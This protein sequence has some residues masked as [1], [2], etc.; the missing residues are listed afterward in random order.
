MNLTPPIPVLALLPEI[1]TLVGGCVV[2]LLGQASAAARRALPWAVLVTLAVAL[3]ASLLAARQ[4]DGPLAHDGAAGS[5]LWISSL[6]PFVRIAALELGILLILANW[7]AGRT[8]DRGEFLAMMLFSISGLLLTSA[9]DNWLLL[10]LAVELVSIPTYVM[11]ILSRNNPRAL[12]A[13]AKYFY[14]GAMSAALLAYGLSFLYGVGGTASIR[15]GAGA[16][17]A[18]LA[19]PATLAGGLAVV[20]VVLSLAGVLFKLA[21]FPMHFYIADVYQGAASPVAGLLGF[22][23]KLAGVVALFKLV[24]VTG[25]WASGDG[26]MLWMLWLVAVLSMTVGNLLALRQNNIKRML[27]YSGVAHA[28]YMIVGV[29]A[30]PE[31]GK[32]LDVHGVAVLGDGAASVLYYTMIYGI[33]NLAAFAV[34]GLL[35]VRGLPCETMRDVTG[36]V[37]RE[38]LLAALLAVAMLTLMGLPPTPGFWGKLGLF[39]SALTASTIAAPG[40]GAW[41]IALVVIAVLNSALAAAYYLRV[42][43][44]MLFHDEE[45]PVASAPREA[46]STGVMLCA[47]LLLIFAVLPGVLY[48]PSQS[49]TSDIR[50]RAD[51]PLVNLAQQPGA[52]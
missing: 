44:A 48:T 43:A 34:L 13:G 14:L 30:G 11:V 33:A 8:E 50:A 28:G 22:V 49:A 31:A 16:I 38:P 20:G 18:A 6:V 41:M 5:G 29:I 9:C 24:E 47:F 19:D 12:E 39:G 3:G 35:R 40:A 26:P 2:L 46:E 32:A 4:I 10:F 23:P 45:R 21:A 17:M 36:L 7:T 15:G 42:V 52:E 37:R 27:G 1:I 25:Y 51:A